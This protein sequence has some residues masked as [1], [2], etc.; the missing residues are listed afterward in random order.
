MAFADVAIWGMRN[1]APIGF[2]GGLSGGGLSGAVQMTVIKQR[3]GKHE[4]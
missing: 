4:P 3:A 1:H 2:N